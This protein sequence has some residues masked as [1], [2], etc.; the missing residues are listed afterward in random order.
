MHT[1]FDDM[2]AGI[3]DALLY[4]K[5]ANIFICFIGLL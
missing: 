4:L 5:N 1:K 2:C 3:L